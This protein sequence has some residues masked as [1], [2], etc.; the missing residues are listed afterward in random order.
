MN[1]KY[2]FVLLGML[3]L[4]GC[5]EVN[6]DVVTDVENSI[7][8]IEENPETQNVATCNIY[9]LEQKGIEYKK[10]LDDFLNDTKVYSV[11]DY[12]QADEHNN[13]N[14][15][16]QTGEQIKNTDWETY[17]QWYALGPESI[18]PCQHAS[19]AEESL[20]VY[21]W[22]AE[23][24]PSQLWRYATAVGNTL[25]CQLGNSNFLTPEWKEQELEFCTIQQAKK[26]VR[27]F[28]ETYG[29]YVGEYM[30]VY[31]IR[32][33]DLINFHLNCFKV[34]ETI[35]P[36]C[37]RDGYFIQAYI[38]KDGISVLSDTHASE[39]EDAEY[40]AIPSIELYYTDRGVEYVRVDNYQECTQRLGT[41]E[42]VTYETAKDAVL[43]QFDGVAYTGRF[44]YVLDAG[45][46][47][48]LPDKE[49][50]RIVTKPVW[51]FSGKRYDDEAGDGYYINIIYMVDACT[52]EIIR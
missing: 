20:S 50:G 19:F 41:K 52:G 30:D 36:N 38:E 8:T 33:D 18:E 46:L 5:Q 3:A 44:R 12:L 39:G 28:L 29:V 1:K 34:E 23:E 35:D 7:I 45:R 6:K 24:C 10:I 15:Y 11:T 21:D 4:T 17:Y 2:I 32:K 22:H 48:Y 47:V 14:S 49:D 31:G 9:G 27:E 40:R 37:C 42:L 25:G 16:D 51:S 26:E 13:V 43:E